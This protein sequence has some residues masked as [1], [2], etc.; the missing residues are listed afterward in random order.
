MLFNSI[1]ISAGG[2]IVQRYINSCGAIVAAG[3]DAGEKNL[4]FA[5][6][7]RESGLLGHRFGTKS[8]AM[9]NGQNRD[10]K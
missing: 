1:A 10:E 3:I 2:V 9:K 6:N 8:G 7:G 4:L 5:G